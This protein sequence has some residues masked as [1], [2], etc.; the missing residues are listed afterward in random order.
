MWQQKWER[1]HGPVCLC[2]LGG[3]ARRWEIKRCGETARWII[4][5]SLFH[6]HTQKNTHGMMDG[7]INGRFLRF[8]RW[9]K[10]QK[11][12]HYFLNS[13]GWLLLLQKL[14]HQLRRIWNCLRF[15][16]FFFWNHLLFFW[17]TLRVE[18]T[19]GEEFAAHTQKVKPKEKEKR[20]Q[21]FQ[22]HFFLLPSPLREMTSST[23]ILRSGES[24]TNGNMPPFSHRNCPPSAGLNISHNKWH[25]AL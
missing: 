12:F 8:C 5:L 15:F 21:K 22:R 17:S 20:Y 14:G 6:T 25:Q 1:R 3:G 2:C 18:R 16:F 23:A 7:F 9:K 24:I 13:F 4:T 19:R 11:K 10:E